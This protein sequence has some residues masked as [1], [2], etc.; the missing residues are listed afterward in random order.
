MVLA[1]APCCF[2]GVI[3]DDVHKFNRPPLNPSLQITEAQLSQQNLTPKLK[4]R[5][6]RPAKNLFKQVRR[7]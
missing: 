4:L 7:P 1:A 2:G 5:T 6:V 3:A